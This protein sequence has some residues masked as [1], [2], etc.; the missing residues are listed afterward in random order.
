MNA[1]LESLAS[2]KE[3]LLMRSALCRLRLRRATHNLRD[4]LHWKRASV[5][6]ANVPAIRRIAFGLAVSLAGFGRTA[7]MVMLAGRIV[8]FAKLARSVVDYVRHRA[9]PFA[10]SQGSR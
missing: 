10:S 7:R 5:A 2:E 3:T 1:R 8:L 4:S 6:V 9:G